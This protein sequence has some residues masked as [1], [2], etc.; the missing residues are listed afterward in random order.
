MPHEPEKAGSARK[1]RDLFEGEDLRAL[2]RCYPVSYRTRSPK[3]F[4]SN[5]YE[6]GFKLMK[7]GDFKPFGGNTYSLPACNPFRGDTYENRGVGVTSYFQTPI[8]G[9]RH[10]TNFWGKF[11]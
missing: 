1:M 4:G 8:F 11:L 6:I 5:T 10:D 9:A 3:P 2:R 7:N